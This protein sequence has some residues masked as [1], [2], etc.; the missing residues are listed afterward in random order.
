LGNSLS[1]NIECFGFESSGGE[2]RIAD[3]RS[4]VLLGARRDFI[5][6]YLGFGKD[7][8]RFGA[9][10]L[11]EATRLFMRRTKNLSAS[12]PQCCS[13][14]L[15]IDDRGPIHAALSLKGVAQLSLSLDYRVELTLEYCEDLSDLLRIESTTN[16]GEV[17]S[18]GLNPHLAL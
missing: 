1:S 9:H 6:P 15:L 5:C 16:D 10:L 4:S 11:E 3:P 14:H 7:L 8:R 17:G 12:L 18:A 13:N 2:F